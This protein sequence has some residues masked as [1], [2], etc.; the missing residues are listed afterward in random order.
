MNENKNETEKIP[1]GDN[2]TLSFNVKEVQVKTP[3]K[4]DVQTKEKT[5]LYSNLDN[6]EISK[7]LEERFKFLE[8]RISD[9]ENE[10][11]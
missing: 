1:A 3:N 8:K 4:A 10:K 9:L 7:E 5:Q 6:F 11:R 2:R